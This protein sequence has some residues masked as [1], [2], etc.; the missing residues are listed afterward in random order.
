MRISLTN[1]NFSMFEGAE[2]YLELILLLLQNNPSLESISDK[3]FAGMKA[4][5]VLDLNNIPC[6]Q[7]L[8]SSLSS[9]TNLRTRCLDENNLKDGSILGDV[10]SIEILSIR[11][12]SMGRFPKDIRRLTNLPL[13]DLTDSHIGEIP[14][15]VF[16]SLSHLEELYMGG[17]YND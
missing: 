6:L 2:E 15:K 10:T 17:S 9:L 16:S 1:N 5:Q 12:S 3:F 4:L 14:S 11:K 13:L 7:K 8:P